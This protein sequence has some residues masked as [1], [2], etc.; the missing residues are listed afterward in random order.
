MRLAL[1]LFALGTFGI[2]P[3][4]SWAATVPLKGVYAQSVVAH[5][6]LDAGREM[7]PGDG[8]NGYGCRTEKGDVACT[9]GG[10]CT[11]TC[12]KCG[13]GRHLTGLYGILKAGSQQ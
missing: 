6:C 5:D 1:L 9:A 11:A 10:Q 7:T 13:T 4:A 2:V 8:P 12:D 3:H